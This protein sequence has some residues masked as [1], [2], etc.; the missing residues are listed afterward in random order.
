[1]AQRGGLMAQECSID[2][3]RPAQAGQ[4]GVNA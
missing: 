1:M 4:I 2:D 3:R